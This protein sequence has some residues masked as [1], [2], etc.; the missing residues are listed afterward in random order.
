LDRCASAER[1][2][3]EKLVLLTYGGY[4]RITTVTQL[5]RANLPS[6]AGSLEAAIPLRNYAQRAMRA[7]NV[8]LSHVDGVFAEY[9]NR[10]ITTHRELGDLANKLRYPEAVRQLEPLTNASDALLTPLRSRQTAADVAAK[11]EELRKELGGQLHYGPVMVAIN[12]LAGVF[13]GVE[14][15]QLPVLRDV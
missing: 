6:G 3:A 4:R 13:L 5:V 8:M 1:Y 14:V 2:L 9:G 10:Y 7:S 15:A 12:L 11:L